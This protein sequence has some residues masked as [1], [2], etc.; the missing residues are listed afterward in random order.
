ME[1]DVCL[2]STCSV[3]NVNLPMRKVSLK[4]F[5]LNFCAIWCFFC[6]QAWSTQPPMKL[7][8][9]CALAFTLSSQLVSCVLDWSASGSSNIS[10]LAEK[11]EPQHHLGTTKTLT[12]SS[13]TGRHACYQTH[14]NPPTNMS[15]YTQTHTLSGTRRREAVK[16]D[17]LRHASARCFF[18]GLAP[19]PSTKI[20]PWSIDR[21]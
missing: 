10:P 6:G 3:L 21:F 18:F 4:L 11:M 9:R 13:N 20:H 19:M 8:H 15:R 14:K 12:T 5:S 7:G 2:Q 1:S 17:E 16:W